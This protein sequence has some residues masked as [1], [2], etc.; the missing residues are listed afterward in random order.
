V[1]R[2]TVVLL[3]MLGGRL[4]DLLGR[5]RVFMWPGARDGADDPRVGTVTGIV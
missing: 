3:A 5:R 1:K 2:A 4:G